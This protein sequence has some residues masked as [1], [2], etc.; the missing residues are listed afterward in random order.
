MEHRYELITSGRARGLDF[1]PLLLSLDE[2]ADFRG[3]LMAWY[4]EIKVKGDST[5]PPVLTK[6]AS[7]GRRGVPAASIWFSALS[8]PTPST[9]AETCVGVGGEITRLGHRIGGTVIVM[10]L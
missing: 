9:S 6:A 2:W 3:N 4:A 5:K 8:G 10:C 7:I 1:E